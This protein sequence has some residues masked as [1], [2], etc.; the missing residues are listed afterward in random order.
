MAGCDTTSNT[1]IPFNKP[2]LFSECLDAIQDAFR[3]GKASGNGINTRK[4]TN[5]FSSPKYFGHGRVL[6][7][8]SCTAALE[9]AALILDLQPGDEVI[10]PSYTFVSTA[11]AFALRGVRLV[12][13]DSCN[14]EGGTP[15][16]DIQDI[17]TKITPK[18]KAI[19]VVH[20]AGTVVDLN[21]LMHLKIP[22]V[23]DC[24]HAIGSYYVED[25]SN[26]YD[27]TRAGA[28]GC[29]STFSFHDTKNI[30]IGEG[31]CLVINDPQFWE[32]ARHCWQY[33][34]NMSAFQE[35]RVSHYTWTTLGSS[36][37]MSDVDAGMLW[38]CL[39]HYDEIQARRLQ[40]W[41]FYHER[42]WASSSLWRKP[43][44]EHGHNGH[45]YYLQFYDVE[46]RVEFEEFME[47]H[48]IRVSNHYK[49]LDS[50]PFIVHRQIS[51]NGC[52]KLPQPQKQSLPSG[53]LCLNAK[54]WSNSIVR[55]PMFFELTLEQQVRVA[56]VAN[57]FSIYKAK[58]DKI[59]RNW[60][61]RPASSEHW[62]A[63]RELRNK[64]RSS[65]I[66]KG[67]I[68]AATH[69]SFMEKHS[70]TYRVAVDN[71]NGC[72]IGFCGHVRNDERLATHPSYRR[73]G[74]GSFMKT[75]LMRENPNITC[76]VLRS[77]IAALMFYASMGFVPCPDDCASGSEVVRLFSRP[78][79]GCKNQG[80]LASKL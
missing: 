45:I 15:N 18:T 14:A 12:F 62:E 63:I 24:A 27:I 36:Y 58:T 59:G 51:E 47:R 9:M 41:D 25:T 4:V 39:Q 31:G 55:L 65:F 77:N 5:L 13:A 44:R 67:V 79:R 23:E 48:G 52:R 64:Y 32:K 29:L 26:A 54:V 74:V 72:V 73:K 35:G 37:F 70:R 66:T 71:S 21:P 78:S 7:T 20:Y 80:V 49:P 38:G 3:S 50:C 61:L 17:L 40:Q 1:I 2:F 60:S 8:P 34:T 6:L 76:K 56:N 69:K 11:N 57:S 28:V 22:I 10:V 30:G 16:V 53:S 68:D 42:I 43:W 33:G 19:V 46:I 75:S